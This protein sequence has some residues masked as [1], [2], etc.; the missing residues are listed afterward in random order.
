MS[1]EYAAR[2]VTTA[3]SFP[4]LELPERKTKNSYGFRFA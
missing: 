3:G 1:V 2:F 4:N